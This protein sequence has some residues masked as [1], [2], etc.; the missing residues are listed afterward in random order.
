MP[1]KKHASDG[2]AGSG[3]ILWHHGLTPSEMVP[4]GHAALLPAAA[5]EPPLPFLRWTFACHRVRPLDVPSSPR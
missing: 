4:D 5:G 3:A 2:G 1:S